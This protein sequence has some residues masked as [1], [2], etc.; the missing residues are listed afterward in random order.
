MIRLRTGI[1]VL[2]AA[3]LIIGCRKGDGFLPEDLPQDPAYSI[4]ING[5]GLAA[6]DSSD[7]VWCLPYG[8]DLSCCEVDHGGRKD[9]LDLTLPRSVDDYRIC[10]VASN[11]PVMI[12]FTADR[13]NVASKTVWKDLSSVFVRDTSGKVVQLGKAII[14]GRGNSTW[15]YPKKPYALKLENGGEILGMPSERRWDLLANWMDRTNLRNDVS[16]EIARR[17]SL[18]WTPRCRFVELVLN[19]R[20]TGLYNI[21][22]HIK[23]DRNRVNIGEGGFIVEFDTNFDEKYNFRTTSLQFPVM[24]KDPDDERLSKEAFT[25]IKRYINNAEAAIQSGD[26]AYS[27]IDYESFADYFIVN[28]LAHNGEM[29]HPKSTYAYRDSTGLLYAGP[30]WDFDWGTYTSTSAGSWVNKNNFWYRY[31]FNDRT[32]TNTLKRRWAIL[33]DT[34][35][36][37]PAYIDARASQIQASEA[38]DHAMWPISQ[39]V[40]GDEKMGFQ[41]AVRKMS[42]AYRYRYQSLENKIAQL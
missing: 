6:R 11:L 19:G 1:L 42:N 14:K 37:I 25:A 22:E 23:I 40:N 7:L 29:V 16:L 34:L 9:T 3:V 27:W 2:L 12:L 4:R 24:V 15:G 5:I 26:R 30:A 13:R 38:A 10:C 39:N 18:S 21:V 28:E 17:T 36:T 35:S 31:L 32:F 41:Q 20:H 8:T 33:R